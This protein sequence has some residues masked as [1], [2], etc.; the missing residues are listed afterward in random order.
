MQQASPRRAPSSP[1]ASNK[2]LHARLR[3]Q[4]EDD[5]ARAT[6]AAAG[7]A[8]PEPVAHTST[9]QP[10]VQGD[11]AALPAP[12]SVQPPQ[13]CSPDTPTRVC[14]EDAD[15]VL[16]GTP[17]RPG[18][19][20]YSQQYAGYR[21]E[22][23][24]TGA[25]AAH[26]SVADDGASTPGD[27]VG[28]GSEGS[29]LSN[30][31][32][33]L[34][35]GEDSPT[36]SLS[37]LPQ[38]G[39]SGGSRRPGSGLAA[40]WRISHGVA[41]PINSP[42]VAVPL[43]G[44]GH[45][46]QR[47]SPI[48]MAGLSPTR[49][50]PVQQEQAHADQEHPHVQGQGSASAVPTPWAP[51]LPAQVPPTAVAPAD[52][53]RAG[54]IDRPLEPGPPVS[55][56]ASRPPPAVLA[57]GE[58]PAP[59]A[60]HAQAAASPAQSPLVAL[61]ATRVQQR[62]RRRMSKESSV[63]PSPPPAASP[64]DELSTSLSSAASAAA[65][66]AARKQQQ[67]AQAAV[68]V[69]HAA[70]PSAAQSLSFEG[71]MVQLMADPSKMSDAEVAQHSKALTGR[72]LGEVASLAQYL[73]KVR[74]S[75]AT[76]AEDAAA[77]ST[78]LAA[79]TATPAP[80]AGA[81]TAVV[82]GETAEA[83]LGGAFATLRQELQGIVALSPHKPS[84]LAARTSIEAGEVLAEA[85]V[86]AA[87]ARASVASVQ[88]QQSREAP[89]GG[90]GVA[91]G[92]RT[93]AAVVAS[94]QQAAAASQAAVQAALGSTSAQI[95]HKPTAA[96]PPAIHQHPAH[97]PPLLV[98]PGAG[99]APHAAGHVTGQPAPGSGG[100]VVQDQM[101]ALHAHI[102]ALQAQNTAI[103]AH[104]SQSQQFAQPQHH[105][106]AEAP[107]PAVAGAGGGPWMH[108][109]LPV[110]PGAVP[111]PGTLPLTPVASA[112]GA[113]APASSYNS[114]HTSSHMNQLQASAGGFTG[115]GSVSSTPVGGAATPTAAPAGGAHGS[116]YA[117]R[118][119]PYISPH[120]PPSAG[121]VSSVYSV[122]GSCTPLA[123]S[124]APSTVGA[125]MG[126]SAPQYFTSPLPGTLPGIA[127][128]GPHGHMQ[129]ATGGGGAGAGSPLVQQLLHQYHLEQQLHYQQASAAAGPVPTAASPL[130]PMPTF[131]APAHPPGAAGGAPYTGLPPSLNPISAA[132]L[133]SLSPSLHMFA[134]PS[135]RA[136]AA[137]A[138]GG[139][140]P[141]GG[142][143]PSSYM[144]M[145]GPATMPPAGGAGT[146]AGAAQ[147]GSMSSASSTA[148]SML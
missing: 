37:Q 135:L 112:G 72:I 103:L 117:S 126:A 48:P 2:A 136:A 73:S 31:T 23:A 130:P 129:S 143:T 82:R 113:P 29:A 119:T 70:H 90:H 34:S 24:S 17:Q 76:G 45:A 9:Q 86:Q 38:S 53:P 12:A 4:L 91:P 26:G 88:L 95:A 36:A 97:G 106:Q 67:Q 47:S 121:S 55:S 79:G 28:S 123:A 71:R 5:E 100:G 87:A 69:S 46:H 35:P 108:E 41:S 68:G 13:C 147:H 61:A 109:H 43:R 27:S 125:S 78:S 64:R 148:G 142:H 146:V 33:P 115:F 94:S 114:Q 66:A 107:Y 11:A 96:A 59:N 51:V 15:S 80:A 18:D 92:V 20:G 102:A 42:D 40:T 65:V 110:T 89:A 10:Q 131:A 19:L 3:A 84:A 50:E 74:R 60:R 137:A 132:Q 62:Q 111:S 133:A 44:Q 54:V 145:A 105:A 52:Q 116:A 49:E 138:A 7:H 118:F 30:G 14:A 77:A 63:C 101:A 124:P 98:I 93:T 22:A 128:G 139:H 81:T 21:A 127:A 140:G 16:M 141:Q 6:P 57:G 1:F 8:A 32:P 39:G 75:V 25:A 99:P 83:S 104:L 120:A 144:G 122:G 85:V 58:S 56:R 134:P